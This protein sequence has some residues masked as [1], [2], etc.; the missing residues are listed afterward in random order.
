MVTV[1]LLLEA[2]ATF[3][4][5]CARPEATVTLPIV[6]MDR[7]SLTVN[8]WPVGTTAED[9]QWGVVEV[10]GELRVIRSVGPD[11]TIRWSRP[12]AGPEAASA[13]LSTGPLAG[14]VCRLGGG[15]R[16]ERE[17]TIWVA[18]V[19]A[20]TKLLG[21]RY[22]SRSHT[23]EL[24]V[25]FTERFLPDDGAA[26]EAR[27]LLAAQAAE[28]IAEVL[29]HGLSAPVLPTNTSVDWWLEGEAGAEPL[30]CYGFEVR[31]RREERV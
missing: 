19:A 17:V 22:G 10:G 28:Q 13:T 30:A 15:S 29:E 11:A 12:L 9:W 8:A 7:V 31:A 14:A 27:G 25:S 20:E 1:E 24:M 21:H 3:A 16:R 4:A 18:S 26:F 6:A 5:L 2:K 23:P